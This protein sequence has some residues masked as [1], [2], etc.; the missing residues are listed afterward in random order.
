MTDSIPIISNQVE[1]EAILKADQFFRSGYKPKDQETELYVD[2]FTRKLL[3]R[4]AQTP[5]NRNKYLACVCDYLAMV[6]KS[7]TG[8]ISWQTGSEHYQNS[9]YSRSIAERTRDALI[10]KGYLTKQQDHKRGSCTIYN[11]TT[12]PDINTLEFKKTSRSSALKIRQPT[13]HGNGRKKKGKLIPLSKFNQSIINPLIAEMEQINEMMER[14]P[15]IS[16]EGTT[17]TD[18]YRQFNDG[19]PTGS[20]WINRGG[21]IYGGWQSKTESERLQFTIGGDDICEVDIKACFLFIANQ[22]AAQPIH[23]PDDPYQLINFVKSNYDLRPLAKLL[24]SAVLCKEGDIKKFPKGRK[25]PNENSTQSLRDQFNL[26]KSAKCSNYVQDILKAFPILKT[27]DL[28]GLELMYQ[29]SDIV[30]RSML[31]LISKNVP[32][33]PVHD[34]LLCRLEDEE[35]V[36]STIQEKMSETFGSYATLEVGYKDGSNRTISSNQNINISSHILENGGLDD[37]DDSYEVLEDFYDIPE[38]KGQD[39][40]A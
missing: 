30:V 29:E 3:G 17:W 10:Q 12:I 27:T 38:P 6:K 18:C 35:E 2:D 8:L 20:Q 7:G 22:H 24:T 5:V 23:L 28:N 26:E 11:A 36:I 9:S 40:R 39:T 21:R 1:E 13:Q 16:P 25:K 37:S 33:Y 15:L 19:D 4:K 34:C 31:S 14:H 32:T